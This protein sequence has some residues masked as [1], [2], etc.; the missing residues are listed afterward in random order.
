M[1]KAPQRSLARLTRVWARSE[2]TLPAAGSFHLVQHRA[3]IAHVHLVEILG[4]H[5][6]Q[7]RRRAVCGFFLV[8]AQFDGG[9]LPALLQLLIAHRHRG[10][11]RGQPAQ[12]RSLGLDQIAHQLK[13]RA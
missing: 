7:H 1:R 3:A 8:V 6:F 9:A 2:K 4:D 10:L 11:V 5:G 12:R 13:L